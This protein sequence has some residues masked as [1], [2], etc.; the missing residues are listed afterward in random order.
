[1]GSKPV[2]LPEIQRRRY[3]RLEQEGAFTVGGSE[4]MRL[5]IAMVDDH[6]DIH[7][8]VLEEDAAKQLQALFV[9][10]EQEHPAAF[11]A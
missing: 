1:M 6:G 8:L 7:V 10:L 11:T 3:V 9:W 4:P 5:E 2:F